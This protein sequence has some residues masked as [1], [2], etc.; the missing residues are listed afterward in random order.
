M[1]E[2]AQ[3][4]KEKQAPNDNMR[5]PANLRRRLLAMVYDLILVIALVF[6]AAMLYAA[7]A[8]IVSDRTYPALESVETDQVVHNLEPIDLG[9]GIGPYSLCVGMGFYIY[10]WKKT[11]QTLGMRA[12]KLQLTSVDNQ[13]PKLWQ[14]LLRC[15]LAVISLLALG[16]GYWFVFFNR[17]RATLHDILSK[18]KVTMPAN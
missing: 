11:G 17:N 5:K 18:T 16:L 7:V 12:W 1:T 8:K 14:L 3:A 10:F 4:A 9:W 13:P 6:C 15:P 2:H